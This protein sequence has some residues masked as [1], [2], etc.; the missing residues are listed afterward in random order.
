MREGIRR[1]KAREMKREMT[2]KHRSKRKNEDITSERGNT[3]A[4][5]KRD[6]SEA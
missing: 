2:A 3:Q 4:E 6:D 1:Q 5:G